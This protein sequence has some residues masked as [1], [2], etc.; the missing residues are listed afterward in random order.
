MVANSY[1]EIRGNKMTHQ[2]VLEKFKYKDGFLY[3]RK[4][5]K[6]IGYKHHSG[7]LYTKVNYK[8]YAIHRLIYLY[9]N[10]Q[11]ISGYEID[12]ID[13]SRDNNLIENLRCVSKNENQ[14]NRRTAKGYSWSKLH[15][16]WRAKIRVNKKEKCLGLHDNEEDAR[17]AYL[18]AKEKYHNIKGINNEM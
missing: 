8:H 7:Y 3:N 9:H 10:D 14:W 15:K 6:R 16:K 11:I 4:T 18:S 17:K 1:I 2:E 13:G 5:S 12:H